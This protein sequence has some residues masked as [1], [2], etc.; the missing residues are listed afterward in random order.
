M[1]YKGYQ[2][3]IEYDDEE[4]TFFGTVIGIADLI[5]FEGNDIKE[6]NVA[7]HNSID[8]YLEACARSNREPNK[9]YSGSFN[10]RVPAQIH[11]QL[12]LLA[13]ATN[14]NLNNVVNDALETYVNTEVNA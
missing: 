14:R 10:V 2:A 11:R 13:A 12:A 4:A 8:A 6:L 3:K 5:M 7:F 1:T 9:V